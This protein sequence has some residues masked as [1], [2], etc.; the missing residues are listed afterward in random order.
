MEAVARVKVGG[1]HPWS[2]T[3]D[4]GRSETPVAYRL[5]KFVGV[6]LSLVL[7]TTH[8][9]IGGF[10]P[11]EI[12]LVIFM[13]WALV[14]GPRQ[15]PL[16][17]VTAS[18]FLS[19]PILLVL[20][21]LCLTTAGGQLIR[22]ASAHAST[23]VWRDY[24]AYVFC[25]A[26]IIALAITQ[27][28]LRRTGTTLVCAMVCVAGYQ[29]GCGG[30]GAWYG[31]RFTA[32]AANPN[33]L[34][35]YSICGSTILSTCERWSLTTKIGSATIIFLGLLS[36]SDAYMMTLVAVCIAYGGA[37]MVPPRYFPVFVLCAMPALIIGVLHQG[38]WLGIL[39]DRF[40]MADE[41]HLRL[42]LYQNGLRAWAKNIVTLLVGNGAGSFSG[43]T[44]PFEGME[45]HCTPIDILSIGGV[46]GLV[47][48]Y[49][50][51]IRAVVLGYAMRRSATFAWM[52]GLLTC[53]LFHYV[54]RHPIFWFTLVLVSADLRRRAETRVTGKM[55]TGRSRRPVTTRLAMVP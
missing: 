28:D 39:H 11:G 22:S 38:E 40:M 23:E 32:G 4:D 31:G 33:Q 9:V 10:S 41:G 42:T 14:A 26:M 52:V 18:L 45:A 13:I 1:R 27:I 36:G 34:A 51:P 44:G 3:C 6:C 12:G 24:C 49:R 50:G 54:G 25:G 20:L 30:A 5:E 19:G 43:D 48:V 8:R 21:G 55:S 16:G 2:A 53:S 7:L 29:Y 17:A 37:A 35:L 47:V 15:R 46:L